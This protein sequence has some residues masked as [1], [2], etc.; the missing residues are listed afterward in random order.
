MHV[1]KKKKKKNKKIRNQS[2]IFPVRV[3][4]PFVPDPRRFQRREGAR[5]QY[6]EVKARTYQRPPVCARMP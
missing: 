5:L 1:N 2:R 4:V 3:R 6:A